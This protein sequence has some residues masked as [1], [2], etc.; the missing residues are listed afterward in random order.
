MKKTTTYEGYHWSNDDIKTLME[1]WCEGKSVEDIASA[2]GST[3]YAVS[4]Q[5]VRL[6]ADGIPLPRRTK[7]HVAGRR[8]S[9]WTQS[10]VEFLIRRRQEKA[11]AEQIALEL[12]RTFGAIQGMVQK[13]RKENVGIPMFG[14]GV[15]RLW[16]ANALR[17]AIVGRNLVSIDEGKKDDAF[18]WQKPVKVKL[19]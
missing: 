8:N 13:L 12:G 10:E 16:D 2:L 5:V 11:T 4:K 19:G 6:R 18:Q 1:L 9:N 14:S 7:G 3:N 17:A 15:R